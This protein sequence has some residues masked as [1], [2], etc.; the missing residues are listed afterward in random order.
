[1][2]LIE[3]GNF[4][5]WLRIALA[6]GG[7]TLLLSGLTFGELPRWVRGFAFLAGFAVMAVGGM[8]SRAHMLKIRPFDNSAWRKAKRT[9]KGD[10]RS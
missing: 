7:A 6:V 8:T 9:Y 2:K 4:V 1:M 10:D 3:H 5:G